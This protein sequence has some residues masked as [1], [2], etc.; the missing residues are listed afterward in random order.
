MK[1]SPK[2]ILLVDDEPGVREACRL[3]LCIDGHMVAEARNGPEALALCAQDRFDLIVTDFAMPGMNGSELA[4]KLKRLAPSQP[5]LMI[6]GYAREADC[7]QNPVDAV[8]PKP[9][10]M[11]ELRQIIAQ[12]LSCSAQIE[13]GKNSA[14]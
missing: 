7:F 4:V 13:I 6:T 3:L 9:F 2:H 11:A 1:T 12:L 14:R 8:L 10:S 5:I